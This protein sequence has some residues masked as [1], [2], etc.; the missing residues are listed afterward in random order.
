[1]PEFST[2]TPNFDIRE[3]A[4]ITDESIPLAMGT[5][6]ALSLFTMAESDDDPSMPPDSCGD[7][8][9]ATEQM[10]DCAVDGLVETG[11]WRELTF[12]GETHSQINADPKYNDARLRWLQEGWATKPNKQQEDQALRSMVKRSV[13]IFAER[14]LAH[15][16]Q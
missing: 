2:H 3:G 12:D 1:M 15:Q 16:L 5:M 4:K 13:G 14:A 11:L 9:D 7:F 6:L 10:I 8:G